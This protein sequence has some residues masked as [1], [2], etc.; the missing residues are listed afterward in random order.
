MAK[1]EKSDSSFGSRV[2]EIRTRLNLNQE[3]FGQG[4]GISVQHLSDIELDKSRPCHDFFYNAGKVYGVDVHYLLY[5]EGEMFLGA[6]AGEK[7]RDPEV[8]HFLYYFLNSGVVRHFV[9]Y[10]FMK[11]YN[12]EAEAILGDIRKN[13]GESGDKGVSDIPR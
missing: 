8:E 4:I 1:K 9:L 7:P 2:R 12:E 6:D 11:F 3:E 10:N 13:P 5:G